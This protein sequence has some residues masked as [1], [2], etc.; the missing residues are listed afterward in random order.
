[1]KKGLQLIKTDYIQS[2][3]TN[4]K[5][6]KI[7]MIT[8]DSEGN[9]GF[10]VIE[11]PVITYHVNKPEAPVE[12]YRSIEETMT[13]TRKCYYKDIYSDMVRALNDEDVNTYYAQAQGCANKRDQKAMLKKLH[14]D[15]RLH[16][17]DVN[18]EDH[19]IGKF[20]D[21]YPA[22]DNNYALTKFFYDIETDI[23]GITGFPDPEEALCPVNII[24]AC[25]K[26]GNEVNLYAFALHYDENENP[27][28]VNFMKDLKENVLP[29]KKEFEEKTGCPVKIILKRFRNEINLIKEFFNVIN[30]EKPD[31]VM[32][33]NTHRFDFPYLYN[34][35]KV[36]LYESN[37]NET[38]EDI[39]CPKEFP[40]KK[41]SYNIDD[42]NT[43]A[44]DNN[45]TVEVA[46]YSVHIDQQNLYAAL[47]KAKGKMESYSLDAISEK[48]LGEH[49]E[50]LNTSMKTQFLDDY[51]NFFKYSLKDT[52][53]L[54]LLEEKGHDIEM[55]NAV[56]T[57]TRTRVEQ[58]LKKTICLRNLA[59]SFYKKGGRILSNNRSSLR[60]K[61]GKPRGAFV[62]DLT[63]IEN[64]GKV[65]FDG[66]EPSQFIFEECSD[67]DLSSLYPSII[68]F[69]NLAPE[70]FIKK[71]NIPVLNKEEM[72]YENKADVFIDE[73]IGEDYVYLGNK[74]LDLPTAEDIISELK[75]SKIAY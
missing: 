61:T 10:K 74:Y 67:L 46:S 70:T 34:R 29:M 23:S 4:D 54:Y 71:Y 3:K 27:S 41:V 8:K 2:Y 35:L 57:I 68:M 17:T 43:D 11:K 58:C 19:Y 7:L 42:Y 59:E 18:I 47:R 64:I 50:E 63:L 40:Y 12:E 9:K 30:M 32:G 14:L 52:L 5:Y 60:T 66:A 25:I 28:Y 49:K 72:L 51:N 36:L 55:L 6:D 75:Q 33:W 31:Y 26:K 65:I 62:A 53:L 45:S 21:K 15:F 20:L 22:V 44:T 69:L 48:E 13:T 73:W 1:M 16:G 37:S 39:M 56:S 24:S 38:I